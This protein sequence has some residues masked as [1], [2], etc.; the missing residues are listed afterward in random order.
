MLKVSHPLKLLWGIIVIVKDLS[1]FV[2]REY[3]ILYPLQ[4]P[5]VMLTTLP[6]L[7]P[8]NFGLLSGLRG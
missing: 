8:I 1:P 6:V 3:E 7:W 4:L 2:S 5:S